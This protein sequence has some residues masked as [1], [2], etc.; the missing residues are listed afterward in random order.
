M[1]LR[2]T[3]LPKAV[4]LVPEF[5][6][7]TWVLNFP[8]K[9]LCCMLIKNY[10]CFTVLSD[11]WESW[12]G[13]SSSEQLWWGQAA[14][15]TTS[16][17]WVFHQAIPA[18]VQHV[19]HSCVSQLWLETCLFNPNLKIFQITL[20]YLLKE[21]TPAT[22]Q[23]Q[24]D[25]RVIFRLCFI[26]ALYL[27]NSLSQRAWLSLLSLPLIYQIMDYYTKVVSLSYLLKCWF[28]K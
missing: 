13:W 5:S 3:P 26:T 11:L 4:S 10:A 18:S 6:S 25:F 8:T 17:L 7:P 20:N 21:A 27:R 9:I 14:T 12:Y 1:W 19:S 24:S 16:M 2:L 22:K 23:W 15:A 28:T